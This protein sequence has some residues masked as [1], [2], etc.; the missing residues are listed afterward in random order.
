MRKTIC[1]K[2]GKINDREKQ[3]YCR[4]CHAKYTVKW[5]AAKV[6]RAFLAYNLTKISYAHK[7]IIE[8]KLNEVLK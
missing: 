8:Q 4:M 3:R 5:R 6:L 1:S 7:R 2:C